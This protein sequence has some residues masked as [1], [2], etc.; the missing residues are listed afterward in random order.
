MQQR[1]LVPSPSLRRAIAFALVAGA[2][3]GI[4]VGMLVACSS[5]QT[6]LPIKEPNNCTQQIVGVSV[7][8][9]P[10]INPT[11]C[12]D[13][14]PVQVRIYQL[15]TDTLLQNASFNDIWKN[16]KDTLKDDLVKVEEFSVFPDAR[17]EI[18]FERDPSALIIAG[19]ALFRAPKGRSWYTTFELPPPPGK[20][21][22]GAPQCT[23]PACLEAGA[24][25]PVLNPK[26][27]L[28]LDADRI[29][30][31]SDHLDDFPDGGLLAE[32]M[33][34]PNCPETPGVFPVGP[35]LPPH[36]GRGIR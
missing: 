20:G 26:F 29:D 27:A 32:A 36:E 16:D 1:K 6:I 19:V 23:S 21:A 15:K 11:E 33:A 28:W 2:V 30:D 3:C 12:G 5:G 4:S 9:S 13:P 35:P 34:H 22:C 8:S 24:P 10:R 31:G 14:R 25:P 7:I 18:K 17:Q